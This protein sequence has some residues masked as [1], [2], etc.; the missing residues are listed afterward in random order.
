[1]TKFIQNE[2]KKYTNINH[3]FL[4]P[5]YKNYPSVL[6]KNNISLCLK[7]CLFNNLPKKFEKLIISCQ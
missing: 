2:I 4:K 3:N 7:L 5:N 6:F 1:M